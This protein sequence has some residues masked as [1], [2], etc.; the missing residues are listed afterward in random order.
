VSI[1]DRS[2]GAILAFLLALPIAPVVADTATP[3]AYPVVPLPEEC[4]VEPV[5]IDAVA[6]ILATP[7]AALPAN[8]TPF[9]VPD[10]AL[11]D[12]KTA[13]EVRAVLHGVF[14]CTNA[15]DFLR[16]YAFFT[17]D[18]VRDFFAGTPLTDDVVALLTAPPRP[19]PP[20]EQRIIR[21]IGRV[22]LLADGRAGV[23]V[24]LDEP[25]DPRREE[26]DYVI[27][28]RVGDRWLVA[29]IHEDIDPATP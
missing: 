9:T 18:F 12:T 20:E 27:L 16:V 13:A 22:R 4:V 17:H 23:V 2:C 1:V 26:P 15:G 6:S 19:L 11:A 24:I 29:E 21:E 28:E 10:G 3:G 5:A 7:E 25:D 14:A 8:S